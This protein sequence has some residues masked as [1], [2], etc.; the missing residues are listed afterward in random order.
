MPIVRLWK[1]FL[2]SLVCVDNSRLYPDELQMEG[3]SVIS[4]IVY[5]HFLRFLCHYHLQNSRQ[6]L[7]SIKNLQS[8]IE[9]NYLIGT[10]SISYKI[11]GIS[12]QLLGDK[13]SARLAFMHSI[14]LFPD[15]ERNT[16][17]EHLSLI[18]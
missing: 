9:E 16:S 10:S 14:E 5:A 4:S 7:N 2:L 17:F 3:P 12:C 15:Q 8:T 13:E 18:S 11:L 1:F 6:C